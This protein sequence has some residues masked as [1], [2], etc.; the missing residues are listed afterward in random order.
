MVGNLN[1]R[2]KKAKGTENKNGYNVFENKIVRCE[3]NLVIGL[4]HESD[5]S[6]HLN[7]NIY[8][9]LND[10]GCTFI[11]NSEAIFDLE[12]Y[13]DEIVEDENPDDISLD[14]DFREYY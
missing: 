8:K 9:V 3:Y 11:D 12:Y 1:V 7:D 5:L 4:A 14:Y 10:S 13:F 2:F 6:L